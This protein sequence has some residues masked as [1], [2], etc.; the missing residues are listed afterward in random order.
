MIQPPGRKRTARLVAS[1]LTS[2]PSIRL[3]LPT[4][5]AP[6][7]AARSRTVRRA[8]AATTGERLAD[9]GRGISL[10]YEAIGDPSDAPLLLVMG[11]GMQL[12]AWP[13]PFCEWLAERG[14]YVVRFDNRDA[15]RSSSID[16]VPVP[17]LGQILSRR[18]DPRQ[19][20]L[21][22]MADDA[23][24]LLAQ[25]GLAPAHVVGASLGGMVAQTVAARHS[26]DVRSLT[27]IMSTTGNRFKGQPALGVYRHFLKRA[28]REREAFIEHMV[29]LF[30]VIGSPGFPRDESELRAAAA[31]SYDRGTNPAG[32]GRQLGA[33]LKSGDRTRELKGIRAPTLV[34]HGGAD[35]LIRPSGARA[36]HKAIAGSQLMVVDG[37]GHDLPEQA[38][39]RVIEAIASLAERADGRVPAAA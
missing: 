37:M 10:C 33:I 35:R 17:G 8:M 12:I 13:D 36:T 23:H 27:S 4:A 22:D 29:G 26:G 7:T 15:G 30:G 38:W 34:I 1:D 19:Y 24:G 11:L 28:P 31:A 6:E 2:V 25:L 21:A 3:A 39:P 9:A 5:P 16:D 32:T 14:F 20:T 18:F